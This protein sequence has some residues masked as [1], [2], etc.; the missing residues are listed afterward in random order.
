MSVLLYLLMRHNTSLSI[1]LFNFY[2][3]LFISNI[4]GRNVIEINVSTL[5]DTTGK[6][7]FRTAYMF[8]MLDTLYLQK[9][10]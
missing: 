5:H 1:L 9:A 10:V 4:T 3:C 7:S 2:L 6:D 8:M